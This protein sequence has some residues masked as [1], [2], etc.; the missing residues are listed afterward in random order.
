MMLLAPELVDL[1]QT[2]VPVLD[3]L[4]EDPV[5]FD[6]FEVGLA[7]LPGLAAHDRVEVVEANT[8]AADFIFRVQLEV[9]FLA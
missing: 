7:H 8:Q 6:H 9:L 2:L 3:D 1:E 4:A 5:L